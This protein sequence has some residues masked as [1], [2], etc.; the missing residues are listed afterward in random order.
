M[1]SSVVHGFLVAD[2]VLRTDTCSIS[3]N[4]FS[5]FLKWSVFLVHCCACICFLLCMQIYW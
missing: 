4:T 1:L 5:Q 3:T 2:S